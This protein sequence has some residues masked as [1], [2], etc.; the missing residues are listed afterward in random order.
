MRRLLT[1]EDTFMIEARGL[2]VVPAPPVQEVRGPGDL[3][4]EL[5]L[6]GG[7]R[8]EATLTLLHEFITPVPAIRR[9]GCMFRSLGKAEVPIGT[10]IW[11]A[12]SVFVRTQSPK[13]G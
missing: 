8:R 5:H 2:I 3:D 7:G 1:I 11:C 4:V 13:A 6:P 9:W 12:E 10:E